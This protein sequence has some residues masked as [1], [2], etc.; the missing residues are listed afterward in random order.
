MDPAEAQRIRR[1]NMRRSM[2]MWLGG[3]YASQLF[4]GMGRATE[5]T[6]AAPLF[7]SAGEGVGSALNTASLLA[8]AGSSTGAQL[9]M[10]GFAGVAAAAAS[11]VTEFQKLGDEVEKEAIQIDQERMSNWEAVKKAQNI[12]WQAREGWMA[13]RVIDMS[14]RGLESAGDQEQVLGRID[15]YRRK[16]DLAFKQL[17]DM[18]DPTSYAQN[19]RAEAE[20]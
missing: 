3:M 5:G 9:L 1:R 13:D 17:Q 8:N 7:N 16:R 20:F 15:F 14:S 2:G 18:Q 4:A 19:Q 6:D 10:G 12:G 11:L